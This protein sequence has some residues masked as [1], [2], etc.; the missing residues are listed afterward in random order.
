LALVSLGY[1]YT[2]QGLYEVVPLAL[3]SAVPA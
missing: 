2:V 1:A 3:S